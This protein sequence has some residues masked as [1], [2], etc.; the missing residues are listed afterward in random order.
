MSGFEVAQRLRELPGLRDTVIVAITGC[1][2]EQDRKDSREAG[3]DRH[4]FKPV[5]PEA[6]RALVADIQK[7]QAR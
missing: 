2:Q 5:S 7:K 1:G 4:L 3:F 6:V